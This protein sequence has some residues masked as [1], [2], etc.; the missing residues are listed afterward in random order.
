MH[1]NINI[2]H[3]RFTLTTPIDETIDG[4]IRFQ[5]DGQKKPLVLILHGFKGFKDW[6]FFPYTAEYFAL[7]G[8]F[9]VTFNFSLNGVRVG[10][11]IFDDLDKF[12]R[13][14]ISQELQDSLF[15]LQ[16]IQDKSIINHEEFQQYWNGEIYV[17]GHSRGGGGAILLSRDGQGIHK[18]VTWASVATFDRFTARQKAQWRRD[19]KFEAINSR[20]KQLITM[21][22]TYLE[23]I[24]NNIEALT[25][26]L[27]V[28]GVSSPILFIHGEQ[29]LTVSVRDA[30]L[31]HET[32][33]QAGNTQA[34]IHVIPK[35]GHTFHAIHPFAGTTPALD[36][37]LEK[38]L[39][40]FTEA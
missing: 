13:N 21:N 20:T 29:D 4:D 35:T 39:H 38:T 36:E 9:A 19:G 10:S 3:E 30:H 2:S 26:S 27:A 32:A 5:Q 18:T 17:L 24:S 33:Q 7:H 40:F 14:T 23:D 12:A 31:L 34:H 37:A 15:I 6:G 8:M 22:L 1:S 11:D 25:P 28:Q 16:A